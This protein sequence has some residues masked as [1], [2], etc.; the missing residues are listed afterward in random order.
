MRSS[1]QASAA[2]VR[3]T[4]QPAASATARISASACGRV[5]DEQRDQLAA[6]AP[7]LALEP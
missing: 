2:A 6:A 5:A 1:P 4:R 7:T 3:G